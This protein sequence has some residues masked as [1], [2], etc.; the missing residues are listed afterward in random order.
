MITLTIPKASVVV[1]ITSSYSL[2]P[3][4]FLN[5]NFKQISFSTNAEARLSCPGNTW[6]SMMTAW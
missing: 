2:T 1:D 6:L 3:R 5:R 4:V